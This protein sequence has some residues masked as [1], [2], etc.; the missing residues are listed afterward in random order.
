MGVIMP[1]QKPLNPSDYAE[2]KRPFDE[3]MR[4]LLSAKPK[5]K[6]AKSVKQKKRKKP[7]H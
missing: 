1:K 5:H 3:V 4:Q 6:T 2:E 7:T